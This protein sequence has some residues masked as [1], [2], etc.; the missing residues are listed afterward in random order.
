MNYSFFTGLM[1]ALA[2]AA[3]ASAA[4]VPIEIAVDSSGSMNAQIEG[5]SRMDIAKRPVSEV[6]EGLDANIA[7]R[8]FGHTY[9]NTE[10]DKPQS[11]QDTELLLNFGGTS[12]E[13]IAAVDLLAPSGWTPLAL[14]IKEAGNDLKAVKESTGQKPILIVLSDGQDSCDGDAVAEAKQL[15]ADGV[16]VTIHVIGFAVDN[17]TKSTLIEIAAAWGV[18]YTTANDAAELKRGFEAIVETEGVEANQP[19]DSL[20]TEPADLIATGG[21][22]FDDAKPFPREYLGKEFSLP[23]HLLPGA[24]ETFTLEVQEGDRLNITGITGEK[25]VAERDGEVIESTSHNIS[26]VITFYKPNKVSIDAVSIGGTRL[27]ESKDSVRFPEDGT[28]YFFIGPRENSSYGTPKD[29]RFV[30]AF[31][32]MELDGADGADGAPGEDGEDGSDGADGTDGTDGEDGASGAPTDGTNHLPID[33]NFF[34][35]IA[36]LVGLFLVW[37]II[38]A[39]KKKNKE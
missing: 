2:L 15:I 18:T 20:S 31:E 13:V 28:A 1:V 3:P 19:K 36:G 21:S 39:L 16:D 26:A 32:G 24:V 22:T 8:A 5:E 4:T 14:T 12:E 34:Y 23:Q 9:G 17:E 10:A 11:C 33:R 29:M 27:S 37:M 7:L 38:L 35:I 30:L 6:F 25:G